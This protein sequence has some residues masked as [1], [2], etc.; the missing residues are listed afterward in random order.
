MKKTLRYLFPGLIILFLVA[1]VSGAYTLQQ[2]SDL[3]EGDII[4]HEYITDLLPVVTVAPSGKVGDYVCNGTADDVQIQAA[5]DSLPAEGGTVYI[6]RGTYNIATTIF[7]KVSYTDLIFDKGAIIQGDFDAAFLKTSAGGNLLNVR[8]VNPHFKQTTTRQGI[9]IHWYRNLYSTI[10]NPVMEKFDTG[11]LLQT[12]I[13]YNTVYN[14]YI[15]D[16]AT[17]INIAHNFNHIIGGRIYPYNHASS[18][19]LIMTGNRN[20]AKNL[21]IESATSA[22]GVNITGDTNEFDGWLELL[23]KG[24]VINSGQY[25]VI[26]GNGS[27]YTTTFL[28]DSGTETF[29]SFLNHTTPITKI[30]DHIEMTANKYLKWTNTSGNIIGNL[31]AMPGDASSTAQI[32]LFRSCN[33]TGAVYFSILRGDGSN[34]VVFYFRADTGEFV[35]PIATFEDLNVLDDTASTTVYIGDA[36]D[37][38]CLVMGDSDGGGLTYVTA[39]NGALTA[40][41]TKPAT[42]K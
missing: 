26:K 19:G 17:S 41:T 31:D 32:R 8:I 40:T 25:N 2:I 39:L 10:E 38:G 13:L 14:P 1:G 36:D 20:T 21:A 24:V 34:T 3:G 23:D 18:T 35:A 5:I 30:G 11:M 28:T 12:A 37:S 9:G 6:K 29:V 16:C 22:T 7:I 4:Y 27:S 42:C 33:T 15:Y